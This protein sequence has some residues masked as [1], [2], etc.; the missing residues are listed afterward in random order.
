MVES[1]EGFPESIRF[2][3][4]QKDWAKNCPLLSDLIYVQEGYRVVIENF[5]EPYLNYYVV[6]DADT[7]VQAIALLGRS[8]KGRA[9]FFLLSAFRD[10]QPPLTM[11]GG[12]QRAIDL[13]EVDAQYRPL[14]EYLLENVFIT[15]DDAPAATAD[16]PADVVLLAKSGTFAQRRHALSGGSVGLFEGKKIGRKK[17]L[18][19]LETAIKELEKKESELNS[20]LSTLR[21]HLQSLRQADGTAAI[22]RERDTLGKLGQERAGVRARVENIAAFVANFDAQAAESGRLIEQY[23]ASNAAIETELVE[24]NA[25]PRKPGRAWARPTARSATSPSSFRRPVKPYMKKTS[26][27]SASKTRSTCSAQN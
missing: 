15:G 25:P 2:L 6:P 19:L 27:S 21:A 10:Y 26:S 20:Q 13:V 22:N 24:S 8:Q 9:N 18:E 23:R 17:N 7:A 14:V 4:Q 11:I 16:F 1:L 12:G 5:L 3:S